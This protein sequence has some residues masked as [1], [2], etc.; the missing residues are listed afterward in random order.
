MTG[1][2]VIDCVAPQRRVLWRAKQQGFVTSVSAGRMAAPHLVSPS[3]VDYFIP[4][5]TCNIPGLTTST[6]EG[7]CRDMSCLGPKTLAQQLLEANEHVFRAYRDRRKLIITHL[8][9]AHASG[10]DL[11][12]LQP[13]LLGHLEKLLRWETS[14]NAAI[15]VVGDHGY[16]GDFCDSASPFLGVFLPKSLGKSAGLMVSENADKLTTHWDLYATLRDIIDAPGASSF[17]VDELP[18]GTVLESWVLSNG[19]VELTKEKIQ[20][21]VDGTFAPKSLFERIHV[22]RTCHE[23]GLPKSCAASIEDMAVISCRDR[24]GVLRQQEL[25]L[26]EIDKYC[27]QAQLL[28]ESALL[29]LKDMRSTH[30]LSNPNALCPELHLN[31]ALQF[32]SF[33]GFFYVVFQVGEGNPAFV[34]QAFFSGLSLDFVHPVSRYETYE[35]WMCL[36]PKVCPNWSC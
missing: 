8:E 36:T 10:S 1:D 12:V 23:A 27:A 35:S 9:A 18:H 25:S 20:V 32:S 4:G 33:N 7:S 28:A 5:P 2:L 3:E 29:P 13:L 30:M 34:Y 24:K 11:S 22:N 26:D 14:A 15:F 31:S 6:T 16:G 19:K 17:G 21:H